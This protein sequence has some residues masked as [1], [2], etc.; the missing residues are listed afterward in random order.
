MSIPISSQIGACEQFAF[1][2]GHEHEKVGVAESEITQ[3]FLLF[4]FT[5]LA[6]D[7]ADFQLRKLIAFGRHNDERGV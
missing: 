7:F 2:D 6:K 1:C 5:W 4:Y 3:L